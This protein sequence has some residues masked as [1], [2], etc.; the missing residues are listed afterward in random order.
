ME[1]WDICLNNNEFFCDNDNMSI[2]LKWIRFYNIETG[3]S[4]DAFN[5]QYVLIYIFVIIVENTT[6]LSESFSC[7]FFIKC[8]L[9]WEKKLYWI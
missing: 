3:I 4:Y 6:E 9:K 8:G 7:I 5:L 2:R 1:F